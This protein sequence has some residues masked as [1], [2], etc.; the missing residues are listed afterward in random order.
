W[1]NTRLVINMTRT[2]K[3]SALVF[4][5]VKFIWLVISKHK[6]E[7]LSSS[8]TLKGLAFL[9]NCSYAKHVLLLK[10]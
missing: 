5:M 8:Y 10:Y 4:C 6:N 1:E 3:N 7:F 9:V 2:N